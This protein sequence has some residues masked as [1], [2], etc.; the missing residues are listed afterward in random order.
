MSTTTEDDNEDAFSDSDSKD[1][2]EQR[3]SAC[4]DAGVGQDLDIS[5]NVFQ[6]SSEAPH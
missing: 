2:E 3:I 4:I 6:A 1:E 5:P